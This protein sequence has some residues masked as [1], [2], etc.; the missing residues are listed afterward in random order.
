ML[1]L[2]ISY[3]ACL[4]AHTLYL[5]KI[6]QFADPADPTER[7]KYRQSLLNGLNCADRADPAKIVRKE[8]FQI[9]RCYYKYLRSKFN[10]LNK[11][12]FI[13]FISRFYFFN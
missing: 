13:F 8:T 5:L 1:L 9:W 4:I 12:L 6:F 11:R 10:Y 7:I 3:Y 2:R